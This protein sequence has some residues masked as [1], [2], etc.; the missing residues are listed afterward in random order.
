MN[1][2]KKELGQHWLQDE[3][4]LNQIIEES[5]I[6]PDDM[7]LEIGPGKGDLTAKLAYTGAVVLA[8]EFDRDLLADLEKRFANYRNVKVVHGDIR[9][10]NYSSLPDN[11]KIVAN[12]PYYLTS[13]L[14]KAIS[15]TENPP[16]TATLLVQKEVAERICAK[17]GQMSILSV[18]AQFYFE[19]GLGVVVPA[20]HFDPPP[21]VDSQVVLLKKRDEKPF[22]VDEKL[23]FRIVKAGFSEKRKTL[24]NSLSGGLTISKTDVEY[25][26]RKSGIN[27][28][29]RAQE[30]TLEAWHEIYLNY[31]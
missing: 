1:K 13:Y 7:V 12:I 24:R 4:I 31:A 6:Q 11:Y 26:L 17:P 20:K 3:A 2:A 9:K 14:I 18:T 30:L 21:K 10:F 23:L 8:L 19:C 15:E 27:S 28:S 5:N 16:K 25:L 29:A 22:N